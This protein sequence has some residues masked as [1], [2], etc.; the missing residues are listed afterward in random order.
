MQPLRP[1]QKLIA[2]GSL[3]LVLLASL[4]GLFVLWM[5]FFQS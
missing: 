5:F 3:L 2:Y 1:V 4:G